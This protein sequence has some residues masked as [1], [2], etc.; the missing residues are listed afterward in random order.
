MANKKTSQLKKD[1]QRHTL[2]AANHHFDSE[3]ME[4]AQEF[5]DAD[6]VPPKDREGTLADLF[7]LNLN[8]QKDSQD[9]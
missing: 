6:Y 8:N 4:V 3:N 2:E 5:F 9:E 1:Y 7:T